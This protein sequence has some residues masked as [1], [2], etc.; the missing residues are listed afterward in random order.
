M[1]CYMDKKYFLFFCDLDSTFEAY[2]KSDEFGTEFQQFSKFVKFVQKFET[3]LNCKV[4]IHFISGV[5]R[6]DLLSRLKYFDSNF[7]DSIYKR[8]D[9]SVISS[10]VIFNKRGKIIGKCD[11]DK[12]VYCKAD[13][14]SYIIQEYGTNDICGACFLGDSKEDIPAFMMVKQF[15]KKYGTYALCTRSSRDYEKVI[16]NVDFYSSKPRINGCVECLEKMRY[17]IIQNIQQK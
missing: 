7:K 15:H 5:D 8:I 6:P 3:E 12:S 2:K 9:D 4:V 14:V 13:G 11:T 1:R 10:G 17:H 16:N